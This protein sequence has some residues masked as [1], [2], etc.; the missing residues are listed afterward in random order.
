MNSRDLVGVYLGDQMAC[1]RVQLALA[2]H[3]IPAEMDTLTLDELASAGASTSIAPTSSV[4]RRLS[5]TSTKR[6]SW[7]RGTVA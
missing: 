6:N 2:S 4:R 3:D 5:T 7:S 1:I